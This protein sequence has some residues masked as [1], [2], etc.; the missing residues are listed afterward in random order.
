MKVD[1]YER[2]WMWGVGIMLALFFGTLANASFRDGLRPPSHVETIDPRQVFATPP[3]QRQGVFVAG[4]G[5][6]NVSV[7][8]LTFAWMPN[9]LTLPADTPVTFHVTSV[10]VTHGYQIVA[11]N[12]QTMVIP[13]YVSRFTTRFD[14]GEYLIACNE[15]CG[16]GHHEMAAKLTVVARDDWTVGRQDGRTGR[17]DGRAAG[18][19]DGREVAHAAH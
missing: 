11:T 1:L 16:I 12:G 15:Y 9:E 17:D 6:V 18:R 3:F 5:A 7:V 4:D 13:G 19:E 2:I 10:D 14:I 8:G